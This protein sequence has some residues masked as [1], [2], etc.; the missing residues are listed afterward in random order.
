MK[1]NII[2]TL[3]EG[4]T[5]PIF[6]IND[7]NNKKKVLKRY[8]IGKHGIENGLLTEIVIM[9][10]IKHPNIMSYNMLN[11]HKHFI[12]I[13]TE[14]MD[15]SLHDL[16]K[17]KPTK[18]QIKNYM[19]QLVNGLV[20]LHSHGYIHNDIKP[21]NILYKNH[22]IK[23]IDFGL[24]FMISYPYSRIRNI[25]TTHHYSAPEYDVYRE[26]GRISLNSD[27]YSL[28]VVFYYLIKPNEYKKFL[29]DVNNLVFNSE[30]LDYSDITKIIGKD[31]SDLLQQMLKLDPD[32]RISS[33]DAINHFYFNK[34]NQKG[35]N[36]L[37]YKKNT[38]T[39]DIINE[40][41]L[42][43]ANFPTLKEYQ[44]NNNQ[45]Q[46]LDIICE[47]ASKTN[48]NNFIN[49]PESIP[50]FY[51][52]IL[53]DLFRHS[54]IKFITISYTLILIHL[55]LDITRLNLNKDILVAC[56]V[57][58]CKLTE[59]DNNFWNYVTFDSILKQIELEI[60]KTLEDIDY[61]KIPL[62]ITN[63][64]ILYQEYIKLIYGLK[65][66]Y[67]HE[68]FKLSLLSFM[69]YVDKS[70]VCRN[71]EDNVKTVM[72]IFGYNKKSNRNYVEIIKKYNIKLLRSFI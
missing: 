65:I 45:E 3:Y 18:T 59:Y 46:F 15:G 6:L 8:S 27:M 71:K 57:I 34:S 53:I 48:I 14:L 13:I 44:R 12:E 22:N 68:Y 56:F 4:N 64:I 19:K 31:G 5:G 42:E 32:E 41:K 16:I 20:E 29:D 25:Q 36:N 66:N 55:Y 10:N 35:G 69:S 11:Y 28:G 61:L 43:I 7:K 58:S 37:S 21:Q 23:I 30:I 49:N 26:I 9:K 51:F 47:K 60:F 70:L 40:R 2:K 17:K 52:N 50:S 63:D 54:D 33:L 72:S 67:Y 62:L 1:Y 24:A 38:F 39:F